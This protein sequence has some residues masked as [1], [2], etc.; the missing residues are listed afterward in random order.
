MDDF[1]KKYLGRM[2]VT[3]KDRTLRTWANIP[4]FRFALVNLGFIL[5][6]QIPRAFPDFLPWQLENVFQ[7]VSTPVTGFCTF[8]LLAIAVFW[9][10]RA[11]ARNHPSLRHKFRKSAGKSSSRTAA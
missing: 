7:A 3:Q 5:L 2:T 4:I 8:N 11:Y 10:V 9:R 6:V 1:L